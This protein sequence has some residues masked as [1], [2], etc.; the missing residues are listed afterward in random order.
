M[1]SFWDR[2]DIKKLAEQLG[3]NHRVVSGIINRTRGVS[4]Y[5]AVELE[6]ASREI[7]KHVPWEA[8]FFNKTTTHKAFKKIDK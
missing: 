8:W 7:G 1:S 6:R 3:V 5:R 2:G 4:Q